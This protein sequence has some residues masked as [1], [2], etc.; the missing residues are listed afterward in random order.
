MA[1][2][3]KCGSFIADDAKFCGNCGAPRMEA[4]SQVEPSASQPQSGHLFF[5]G[6]QQLQPSAG[7]QPEP[8]FS[9]PQYTTG[10]QSQFSAGSQL[11]NSTP[12]YGGGAAYGT[13]G[14]GYGT[15]AAVPGP[16]F[17]DAVK[18]CFSKY[19]TFDG[20]ARRSEYWYFFLFHF[21]VMLVLGVIGIFI[22]GMP[23]YGE[24]NILQSL[25]MLATFLPILAV[26]CRRLHD[27]GKPGWWL[28]IGI[29]PC[30]GTIVLLVF[31]CT[32]SVPGDNE[33]GPSPK[34]P[35]A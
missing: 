18:T 15:G 12:P 7:S 22:F 32:D 14:T 30:I 19:A 21:L 28:L 33:Y 24:F 35:S 34:Y 6:N 1:I 11:Q 5:S 20:R 23:E 16:G 4:K 31:Y 8:Q 29:V 26:G 2:C 3:E 13:G 10:S 25:Y 17:M 27:T 9:Q